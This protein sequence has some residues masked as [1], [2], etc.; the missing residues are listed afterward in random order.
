MSIITLKR[1]FHPCHW[2]VVFGIKDSKL[3]PAEEKAASEYFVFPAG[4]IY[5][6]EK[7][8]YNWRN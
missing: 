2:W 3:C 5:I 7:V 8:T 6:D 1:Q 4:R